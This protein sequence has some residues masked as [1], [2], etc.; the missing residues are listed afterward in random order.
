V[1]LEALSA[2]GV[3]KRYRPDRLALD[4]VD[5]AVP[6][7]SVVALVGPNGAGKSTLIRSWLGFERLDDGAVNVRGIDHASRWCPMGCPTPTA[8]W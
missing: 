1:P 5:L 6:E 8:D 2:R 4:H 7:G 3:S